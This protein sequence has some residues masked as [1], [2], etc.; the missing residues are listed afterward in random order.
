MKYIKRLYDVIVAITAERRWKK[1]VR[2]CHL[3]YRRVQR[4]RSS[5]KQNKT[6]KLIASSTV[7]HKDPTLYWINVLT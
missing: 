7:C 1:L 3:L 5:K 4:R 2:Y 6:K